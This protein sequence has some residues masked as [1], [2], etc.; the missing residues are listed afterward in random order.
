VALKELGSKQVF[1]E[2]R[3]STSMSKD[4]YYNYVTAMRLKEF[5]DK[6]GILA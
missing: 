5:E 1:G 3:A 2:K 4:E 6:A